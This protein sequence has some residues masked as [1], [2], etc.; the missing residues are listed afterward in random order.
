M[1]RARSSLDGVGGGVE[2]ARLHLL[3]QALGDGFSFAGDV[4][5]AVTTAV[6]MI[7]VSASASFSWILLIERA[8]N[9]LVA[10][11]LQLTTDKNLILL[12]LNIVMLI[13]PIDA[14]KDWQM[15]GRPIP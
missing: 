2:A 1:P 6:V 9:G 4:D 7:I 10:G 8:A 13:H 3:L 15:A 11:I 14:I 5:T 12:W